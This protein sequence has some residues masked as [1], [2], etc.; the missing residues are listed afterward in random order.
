[1]SQIASP[2]QHCEPATAG[3]LEIRTVLVDGA[4]AYLQLCGELDLA[5]A[6]QL[7]S[8]LTRHLLG[9]RRFVRL[10]LSGLDF[11]DCAGLRSLVSGHN[12]YL[13]RGGTLVLTHV[14][15]RPARLL[16]ITEL[17]GAL[18]IGSTTPERGRPHRVTG[19]RPLR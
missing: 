18:L 15:P 14:G 2:R 8:V 7:T 13:A 3:A 16:E 4:R 5:T 12:V 11:L 17:D 6:D 10:D 19:R 1:M 9:G